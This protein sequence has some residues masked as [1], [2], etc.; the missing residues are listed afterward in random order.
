MGKNSNLFYLALGL[1][2]FIISMSREGLLQCKYCNIYNISLFQSQ[3]QCSLEAKMMD[4]QD[5]KS[6][7][8]VRQDKDNG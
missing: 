1:N 7:A 8:E 3:C 6:S 5:R 2:D 4:V